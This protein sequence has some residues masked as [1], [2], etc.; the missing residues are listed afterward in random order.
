MCIILRSKVS[1]PVEKHVNITTQQIVKQN[2]QKDKFVHKTQGVWIK[3]KSEYIR[4]EE[5][6]EDTKVNVTIKF[7]DDGVKI[8]RKGDIHMTLH[9]VEGQDTMTYYHIPEGKMVLSVHTLS[10]LHFVTDQ[11]GKLKVHYE[12]YQ[13]DEKMGIYQYEMN[14]QA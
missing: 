12:L 10:I 5:Q 3:R 11:G 14:Y 2:D 4:Y 6:I 13:G 8:I 7:V 1:G 9:F